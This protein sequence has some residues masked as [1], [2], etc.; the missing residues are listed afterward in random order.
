MI[1]RDVEKFKNF[2]KVSN[3]NH[4]LKKALL[5][6]NVNWKYLKTT[7]WVFNKVFKI[8]EILIF[9]RTKSDLNIA[10]IDEYNFEYMKTL[11]ISSKRLTFE[12][13]MIWIKFNKY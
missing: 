9:I 8:L 6:M 4:N 13:Y 10:E 5:H 7:E 12:K 3:S 1:F 2:K 11:I